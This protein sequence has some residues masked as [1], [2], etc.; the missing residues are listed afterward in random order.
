MHELC[1]FLQ[2]PEGAIYSQEVLSALELAKLP[3]EIFGVLF[4]VRMEFLPYISPTSHYKVSFDRAVLM[5]FV[6]RFKPN[7]PGHDHCNTFLTFVIFTVKQREALLGHFILFSLNKIYITQHKYF[8][9]ISYIVDATHDG[10]ASL[11]LPNPKYTSFESL[12]PY[13]V[14]SPKYYLILLSLIR[15]RTFGSLESC[16]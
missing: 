5:R 1:S 12:Y 6:S 16:R 10:R 9:Y 11:L 3:H 13:M 2:P 15:T 4:G 8:K 7:P 14:T